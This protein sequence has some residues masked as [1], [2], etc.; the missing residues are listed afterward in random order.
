LASQQTCRLVERP[1]VKWP[2]AAVELLPMTRMSVL[3]RYAQSTVVH[4]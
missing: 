4:S 3:D 2:R 1:L